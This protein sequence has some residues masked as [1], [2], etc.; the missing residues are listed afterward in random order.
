MLGQLSI[1]IPGSKQI[2]IYSL[3]APF[4]VIII[5]TFFVIELCSISQEEN[6][7]FLLQLLSLLKHA[8][9]PVNSLE[10]V[11]YLL[12]IQYPHFCEP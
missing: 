6:C 3:V 4:K 10:N 1:S 9:L 8:L 7:L 11:D 12:V 5:K 2:V